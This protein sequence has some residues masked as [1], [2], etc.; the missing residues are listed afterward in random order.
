MLNYKILKSG[1]EEPNDF[2]KT[3]A[4]ALLELEVNSELKPQ[5]RDLHI[6]RAREIEFNNK[7]VFTYIHIIN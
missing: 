3:I 2:E 6:T 4:Q 1:N 5:L 7:K